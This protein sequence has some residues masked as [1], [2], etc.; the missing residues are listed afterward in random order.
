MGASGFRLF[1]LY[2]IHPTHAINSV[3]ERVGTS[4]DNQKGRQAGFNYC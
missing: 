1:A 2:V 4:H 3:W